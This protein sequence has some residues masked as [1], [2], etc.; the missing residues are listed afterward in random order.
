M[1]YSQDFSSI[2]YDKK[3]T[4][5]LSHHPSDISPSYKPLLLEE[6]ADPNIPPLLAL[7]SAAANILVPLLIPAKLPEPRERE[8]LRIRF[9]KNQ[10][11]VLDAR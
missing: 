7:L 11:N 10:I 5:S 2:L 6:D 8:H 9:L 4:R 1:V 3:L